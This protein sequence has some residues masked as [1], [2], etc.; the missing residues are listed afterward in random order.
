MGRERGAKQKFA[1]ASIEV[2]QAIPIIQAHFLCLVPLSKFLMFSD[3]KPSA[4][5]KLYSKISLNPGLF[6]VSK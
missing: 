2:H 6:H 1:L 4:N 5:M 3:R